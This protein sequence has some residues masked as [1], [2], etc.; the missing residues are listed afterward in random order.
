MRIWGFNAS[1]MNWQVLYAADPAAGHNEDAQNFFIAL[2]NS[3]RADQPPSGAVWA[4]DNGPI[5]WMNSVS[6]QKVRLDA[7]WHFNPFLPNKKNPWLFSS[8]HCPK[9][10]TGPCVG[11]EESVAIRYFP[12]TDTSSET[13][14]SYA[15]ALHAA[16]DPIYPLLASSHEGVKGG[17]RVWEG[18]AN[19]NAGLLTKGDM[20]FVRF[21]L[22]RENGGFW[23]VSYAAETGFPRDDRDAEKFF[24][25]VLSTT[26]P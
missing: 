23:R 22:F 25:S 13:L 17:R 14:P 11:G 18:R 6:G 7:R 4:K 21:W 3:T 8:W 19:G 20:G 5:E 9:N 2:L 16:D 24:E 15:Q 10:S 26:M 1:A 12:D